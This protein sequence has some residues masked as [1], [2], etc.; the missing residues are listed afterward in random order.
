MEVPKHESED[1][2]RLHGVQTV[3]LQHQEEQEEQPRQARDEEV[4]PLSLIH[5]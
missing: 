1:H 3:Q 5:I 2:A 4:L